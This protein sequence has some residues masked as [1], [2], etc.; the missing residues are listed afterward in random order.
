VPFKQI[1][2]VARETSLLDAPITKHQRSENFPEPKRRIVPAD[3]SS[4]FKPGGSSPS[5]SCHSMLDLIVPP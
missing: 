3:E 4:R 5:I 2:L 1:S